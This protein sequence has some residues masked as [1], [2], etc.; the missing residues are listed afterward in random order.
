VALLASTAAA[1]RPGKPVRVSVAARPAKPVAG[2]S[3]TVGLVVRNRPARLRIVVTARNGRIVRRT[4]AR[5]VTPRL[6][7]ARLTVP[8]A[9]SWKLS[10]S[11]AGRSFRLGAVAVRVAPP[12]PSA[13]PG[14][15]AFS[16]CRA[17][18]EPFPQ[19]SIASGLGALWI[20]CRAS[21]TI[22]RVDPAT[23]QTRGLIEVPGA[24]PYALA[25]GL[26]SLWAAQRQSTIVRIDPATGAVR[27]S[28][29]VGESAYVFTAVGSVW[30][31]NDQRKTLIRFT[32]GSGGRAEMP[33][34][35]GTSALVEVGSRIWIVNHR[36]ATL[37]RIDTATNTVTS[38]G[39]LPGDAPERMVMSNGSLWITGRGADLLRVDPETGAVQ[40]IVDIGAGGI[41][42]QAA[43]G[44]IWVF[45]PTTADDLSGTPV[46]ERLIRVDQ[47]TNAITQVVRP[48]ARVVVTGVAS[49]GDHVWLA[50]TATGRL[51]RIG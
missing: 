26:G 25:A 47:A 36:D 29:Q 13:I 17:S 43:A 16:I 31:P 38:L 21:N 15:T 23:G 4:T 20:G 7:R 10:A 11:A 22:L 48:T 42:L 34:G 1:A 46:L 40:A 12:V 8:Y 19:Y 45:A 3:W 50:D 18:G 28:I 27:S 30:S 24:D 2:H 5:R 51:F 39:K 41:N 37:Q 14:A 6:Y 35:D 33:V 9:G 49:T 32:P 44:S